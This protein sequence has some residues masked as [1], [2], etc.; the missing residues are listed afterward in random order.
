MAEK[1]RGSGGTCGKV[2]HEVEVA[3]AI[4]WNQRGS[5][6]HRGTPTCRR[7]VCTVDGASE[8]PR[9]VSFPSK[10]SIW[11]SRRCHDAPGPSPAPLPVAASPASISAL[12]EGL[13][14]LVLLLYRDWSFS[15]SSSMVWCLQICTNSTTG[16]SSTVRDWFLQ[17]SKGAD[18]VKIYYFPRSATR[19]DRNYR[20]FKLRSQVAVE[21]ERLLP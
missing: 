5:S 15:F 2:W 11:T 13:G 7:T 18:N 4:S 3:A 8:Q 10:S 6:S 9:D 16:D 20:G 1:A 12:R 21:L 19:R 17:G 14:S